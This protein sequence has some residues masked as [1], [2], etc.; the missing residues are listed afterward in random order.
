MT[1][2]QENR[3][4]ALCYFYFNMC[5][6]S[7][8]EVIKITKNKVALM[9]IRCIQCYY[10]DKYGIDYKE[11]MEKDIIHTI[12][13]IILE[14]QQGKKSSYAY[15]M[16]IDKNMIKVGKTNN[17][18]QRLCQLRQKYPDIYLLKSYEFK[19]EEDAYMFEII[20]HRYF[21]MSTANSFIPQDRF[22]CKQLF[23]EEWETL[24][25]L[26]KQMMEYSDN[27]CKL[28]NKFLFA[29]E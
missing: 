3:L 19:N 26:Y 9:S 7:I 28:I 29:K 8:E 10:K 22:L 6:Y 13:N 16:R 2:A 24:D 5:G 27:S 15:V 4:E 20:L 14:Q 17:I 12:I 18:N 23:E 25:M 21:K 1:Y 11:I